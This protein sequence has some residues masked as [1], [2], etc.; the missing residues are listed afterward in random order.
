MSRNLLVL[1]L[2]VSSWGHSSGN[3][4]EKL[5]DRKVQNRLAQIARCAIVAVVKGKSFNPKHLPS[6]L[7][8]SIRAG[9]FV[10]IEVNGKLRGCKG[11][12]FPTQTNLVAEIIQA[13]VGA[14]YDERFRPLK[15]TE[16]EKLSISITVVRDLKPLGDIFSLRPEHG[17]VVKRG[18]KIGIVLPYEGKD[19]LVRLDWAKRKAGLKEGE[20]FEMWLIECIRWQ[21][22][23][24][25]MAQPSR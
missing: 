5:R 23:F 24:D 8:I 22:I 7:D 18:D 9:C 1:V 25:R 19:P 21:A 14:C 15:P 16:L 3:F 17:L 10:T 20:T 6:S 4:W 11:T 13:S 12:L 2:L